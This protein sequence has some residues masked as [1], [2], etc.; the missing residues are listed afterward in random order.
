M[1]NFEFMIGNSHA[2]GMQGSHSFG[3]AFVIIFL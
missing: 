1:Y 3:N 2:E